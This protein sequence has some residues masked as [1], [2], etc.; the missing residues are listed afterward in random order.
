[1]IGIVCVLAALFYLLPIGPLSK[2]PKQWWPKR[3]ETLCKEIRSKKS[4]PTS[5]GK[6]TVYKDEKTNITYVSFSRPNE[7]LGRPDIMIY[8]IYSDGSIDDSPTVSG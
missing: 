6:C 7:V 8:H 4:V 1:M 2:E 3:E 5:Y